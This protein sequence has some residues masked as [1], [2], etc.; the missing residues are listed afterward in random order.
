M[1]AS[2][3]LRSSSAV[4]ASMLARAND[5]RVAPHV[6]DE[7]AAARGALRHHHGAAVPREEPHGRRVDVRRQHALDAAGEER[8]PF[9][10]RARGGED[11]RPF[12]RAGRRNARGQKPRHRANPSRQRAQQGRERAR[13]HERR[14]KQERP[15]HDERD[16]GAQR[17]VGEGPPE[18][19]LDPLPRQIDQVHVIDARRA[20]RHAGEARKTAV[21]MQ[22]HLRR[23][24]AP[25]LEHVLDEIYPAARPVELVAQKR[26]GR[27]GRVAEAAMDARPQDVD[28]HPRASDR[29]AGRW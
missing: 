14:A 21:D 7:P 12:D 29:R 15:R 5:E 23:S 4:H 1:M 24:G 27:A 25:A 19:L 20:R 9:P 26:E 10:R 22:R 28:S 2:S 16:R 3:P 13:R 18:G 11:L 8:H 6:M 17:P